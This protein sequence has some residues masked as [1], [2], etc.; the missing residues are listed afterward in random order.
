MSGVAKLQQPPLLNKDITYENWK[1]ELEIWESFTDLVDEKKGP[2]VFLSLTGQARDVVREG[3]DAQKMKEKEGIKNVKDCLDKFYLKDTT[4]SAYE[5]YEEFEKFTKPSDM[6]I[7][8]YIIKFEQLY[9]R[10]KSHKMEILDGVLAYRLLN[11]AGLTENHKQLVR[12]T[13]LEMKY[14]TMKSQVEKGIY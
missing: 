9:S 2:A 11:G 8:D 14:D 10:A 6:T 1:V 12:A 13:V 3:V 7:S 5:A 4:C